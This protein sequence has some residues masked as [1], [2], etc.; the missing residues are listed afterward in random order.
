MTAVA[1]GPAAAAAAP[2]LN[3]VVVLGL[4]TGRPDATVLE[5]VAAEVVGAVDD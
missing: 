2:V 3:E 4:D 5:L 1:M